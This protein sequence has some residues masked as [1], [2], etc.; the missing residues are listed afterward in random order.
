MNILEL[1]FTSK[2]L[3]INNILN[4]ERN[5]DGSITFYVGPNTTFETFPACPAM[6]LKVGV[7]TTNASYLFSDFI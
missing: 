7:H 1:T 5:E 2:T 4:F 6:N 3:L